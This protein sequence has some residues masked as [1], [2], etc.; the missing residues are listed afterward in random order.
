[1]GIPWGCV[2]TPWVS[3]A[4]GQVG[5]SSGESEEITCDVCGGA[6]EAELLLLCDGRRGRCPGA[7]H[8]F[9][10][11]LGRTVP[12]GRWFCQTCRTRQNQA[13]ACPAPKQGSVQPKGRGKSRRRLQAE[14]LLS[15]QVQQVM[16]LSA[17]STGLQAEALLSTQV[18]QVMSLSAASTGSTAHV[19]N[20]ATN[21]SA[22]A[23]SQNCMIQNPVNHQPTP[24]QENI[25]ATQEVSS[26]ALSL[27]PELK[28]DP[29]EP[30]IKHEP[31]AWG[32]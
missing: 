7:C 16:S 20:A 18:Q 1:M 15:T 3:I 31:E 32:F 13:R 5:D 24:R 25:G 27:Q 6:G 11:G 2:V 19:A 17:A 29:A 30:A 14:A 9:C 4:C 8:T 21:A 28:R 26:Q 12:S 10:D 22:T 23:S